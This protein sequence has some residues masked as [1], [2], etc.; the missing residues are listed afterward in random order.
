MTAADLP[1][2]PEPAE[3]EPAG[4]EPADLE[5]ETGEADDRTFEFMGE[6]FRLADKIG[7]YAM[8]KF[9]RYSNSADPRAMAAVHEILQSAVHEDDW[10]RFEDLALYSRAD[11]DDLAAVINAAGQAIMLDVAKRE[12]RNRGIPQ[13][14]QPP[15]RQARQQPRR[16]PRAKRK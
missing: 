11:D 15:A 10:A 8:L 1:A 2:G 5:D 12:Q 7:S 6:T 14:H 16:Q 3:L 13:D 9:Q 4:P